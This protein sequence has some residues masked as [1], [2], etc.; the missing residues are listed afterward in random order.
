MNEGQKPN[1]DDQIFE[2]ADA[3]IA[4]AQRSFAKAAKAALAENDK[5]GLPTHGSIKGRLIVR[6]PPKG[7]TV[8]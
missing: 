6:H 8:S 1:N 4:L 3:L 5:L 2:D 7:T